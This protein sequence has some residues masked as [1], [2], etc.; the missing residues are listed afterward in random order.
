MTLYKI[1]ILLSDTGTLLNKTIK[2][3]TKAPYNHVS[4]SLDKEL[5]EMYSFG[6]KTP[7]NPINAGF[8]REDILEGTYK[9]FP[10]TTCILYE[11]VVTKK[12]LGLIRRELSLFIENSHYYSYN[13]LG[14]INVVRQKPC[15]TEHTFFCSQ[16]VA[17]LLHRSGVKLFNK[18]TSL[19]T[20]DDFRNLH[21]SK[22]IYEGKL[23]DYISLITISLN[24]DCNRSFDHN[25]KTLPII[26]NGLPLDRVHIYT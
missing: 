12:Q 9:Y 24:S 1:Y 21:C 17:E 19:V 26:S 4:L 7:R 2:A 15:Q 8:V 25:S 6:R 13:L 18:C 22:R 5:I 16:F 10:N 14:F 11:I 23:R 3:Y 20:P